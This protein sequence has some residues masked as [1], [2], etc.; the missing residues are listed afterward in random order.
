MVSNYIFCVVFYHFDT[1]RTMTNHLK[2]KLFNLQA[3]LNIEQTYLKALEID[4]DIATTS[5]RSNF[6]AP[7]MTYIK[8]MQL[9]EWLTTTRISINHSKNQ[10][11]RLNN[12][13]NH[14]KTLVNTEQKTDI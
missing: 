14:L 11:I 1:N 5:L 6:V 3:E 13:I 12:Q 4:A 10:I 8:Q 9:I 7:F 2:V